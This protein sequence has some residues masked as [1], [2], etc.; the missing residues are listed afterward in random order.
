MQT[1]SKVERRVA[2]SR[3]EFRREFADEGR[4]VV[5]ERA[6]AGWRALDR[7]TFTWFTE[8]HGHLVVPVQT[9]PTS[10][11]ADVRFER[12]TLAEY[13][14]RLRDPS[15][16][17]GR[18]HLAGHHLLQDVRG[19]WDDIAVP[20][21]VDQLGPDQPFVFLS[22]KGTR[23]PLHYDLC[24]NFY[25]QVHGRKRFVLFAPSQRALLHAPPRWRR[26]GWTSPVDVEAPDYSRHPRARSAQ[27]SEVVLEA[28]EALLIPGGYWHAVHS[29][30]D[31]IAVAFFWEHSLRQRAVRALL[32][33]VGRP[34][35]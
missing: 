19:L 9:W 18:L 27:A 26:A 14:E 2:P 8:H 25:V 7:W 34:T 6:L 31:S 32:R 3:R 16:R 11:F 20:P 15:G 33:I 35:T 30:D 29:L 10:S 5:V 1:S 24:H 28:G 21:Y 17:E 4:P 22:G 12:I 13:V 23:T